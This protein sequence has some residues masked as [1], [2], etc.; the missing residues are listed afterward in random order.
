MW[1]DRLRCQYLSERFG[2]YF[3]LIVNISTVLYAF[4][5]IWDSSCI[6]ANSGQGPFLLN[7]EKNI[8]INFFMGGATVYNFLF[9]R[10]PYSWRN[11]SQYALEQ[12]GISF[13]LQYKNFSG[14]VVSANEPW[15][16]ENIYGVLELI[17]H[18]TWHLCG[19]L[20]LRHVHYLERQGRRLTKKHLYLILYDVLQ[21]HKEVKKFIR[22]YSPLKVM[23]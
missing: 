9:L 20:N 5:V 15:E 18:L 13:S 6:Q 11:Y 8:T 19:G 12:G 3:P 14:Q 1:G 16:R 23:N 4:Y 7:P 17:M 10:K 2:A 21:N 22:K